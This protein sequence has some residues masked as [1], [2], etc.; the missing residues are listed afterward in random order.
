LGG[1]P[2][3]SG[4]LVV[5]C[6]IELPVQS[7]TAPKSQPWAIGSLWALAVRDLFA[8]P[9]N[10]P[11]AVFT[12][13]TGSN[14]DDLPEE[15]YHFPRTYLRQV[16]A[17][18]GD[19]I[20]YYEP[21]RTS[22]APSSRGGRQAYFATARVSSIFPDPARVDHFYALIAD[23]LEFDHSVPFTEGNRY[24]ESALE[25]EDGNTN[26]GA[27][28]R[29][30]R[31]IKESEF[32]NILRSG[33]AKILNTTKTSI[34]SYGRNERVYGIDDV[35]VPFERPI[36]ESV[37]SRPFRDA[38]F[39]TNVKLVY[40]NTCAMTGLRLINGGGRAE[41]QAAH[42]R[43]VSMGGSDSVRNGI[44]LSATVHWMFDRGLISVDDDNSIII[45]KDKLPEM[46]LR[47]LRED[48]RLM[49]PE[50]LDA[51]PNREA[52][53]FHREKIFKG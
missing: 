4:K 51:F 6:R 25:R 24:Y 50:R 14:Y 47:L 42:I 2:L 31:I 1:Y 52:L 29:S 8:N 40:K 5:V 53:R 41:V 39:A 34:E 32:D 38:A 11:N 16:E 13:K 10:M 18:V 21:R 45:A 3:H 22:S 23:F 35:S 17:V 30:V 49:L 43:P 20:V 26:R 46:A 7:T 12:T 19:W 27:F 36:V 9:R 15:R 28:G 37:V 33:F 44:A 48:R